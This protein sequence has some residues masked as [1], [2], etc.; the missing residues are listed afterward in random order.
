MVKIKTTLFILLL[1][2]SFD[3]GS[4]KVIISNFVPRTKEEATIN[5]EIVF[6]SIE[7]KSG[8][9][10]PAYIDS[11]Y[12]MFAYETANDL[13]IPIKIAFRVMYVESKF[14]INVVSSEGAKG[15][16]QVMEE[17]RNYHVEKQ[18]LDLNNLDDVEQ[19]IKIGMSILNYQYKRFGSWKK[20]L[21]AYN[22]GA[23]Y[24]TKNKELP[25][26]TIYYYNFI[27]NENKN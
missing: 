19:N 2:I 9:E 6:N 12:I 18:K 25:S 15:M 7:N 8:I 17:T 24:V 20:A 5:I 23:S 1:L 4:S 3:V 11:S 21:I 10:L 16:M 27:L 14:K 22:A 13:K 26:K